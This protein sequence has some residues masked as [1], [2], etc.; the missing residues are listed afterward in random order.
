M[1]LGMRGFSVK[2]DGKVATVARIARHLALRA[3]P[4]AACGEET[5]LQATLS[6]PPPAPLEFCPWPARTKGKK[7]KKKKNTDRVISRLPAARCDTTAGQ[8]GGLALRTVGVSPAWEEGNLGTADMSC[9]SSAPDHLP[10][11]ASN[12]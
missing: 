5:G 9:S 12:I 4:D 10:P 2:W 8:A 1:R 7:K 11:Q 3:E 6:P